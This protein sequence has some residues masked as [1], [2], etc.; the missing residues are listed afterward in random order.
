LLLIPVLLITLAAAADVPPAAPDFDAQLKERAEQRRQELDALTPALLKLQKEVNLKNKYFKAKAKKDAGPVL[1]AR[2]DW[3]GT[4]EN[5]ENKKAYAEYLNSLGDSSPPSLELSSEL[6]DKL[7]ADGP[8]FMKK[9]KSYKLK[10]LDFQWITDMKKYD[11]WEIGENS[12]WVYLEHFSFASAPF[13]DL[14]LLIHWAKLRLIKGVQEHNLPKAIDEVMHLAKLTNSTETLIGTVVALRMIRASSIAEDFQRR[15]QYIDE[16]FLHMAETYM[17]QLMATVSNPLVDPKSLEQLLA[18]HGPGYCSIVNE[19]GEG[20]LISK[21]LLESEMKDV[22]SEYEKLLTASKVCRWL[23]LRKAW[24]GDPRYVSLFGQ[25]PNGNI[26][27]R[28]KAIAALKSRVSEE[29]FKALN[30]GLKDPRWPQHLGYVL[31]L[32]KPKE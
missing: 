22:Y 29:D 13:P 3:S 6:I 12:P 19:A 28:K 1:N 24:S 23:N 21:P 8:G 18:A 4:K 31:A 26:D 20:I 30:D 5:D 15:G 17:I 10:D 32:L 9:A 11:F 14:V 25:I 2:I 7:K 27:L 16:N